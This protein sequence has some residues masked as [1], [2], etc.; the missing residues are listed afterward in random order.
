MTDHIALLQ[1]VDYDTWL[2]PIYVPS[3]TRAGT[4]PLLN[5][6]KQAPANVQALV[7]IVVRAEERKAYR[8]EYPWATLIVVREPG[9]GPARS[10]ALRHALMYD[11][12]RI[13]M[14]DGVGNCI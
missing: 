6:L 2:Y 13:I 9:L 12:Q 5:L 1:E 8:A 7:H 3:Y 10:R 11:N 14:M 4:A